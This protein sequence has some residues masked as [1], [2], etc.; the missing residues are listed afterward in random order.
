ME[1]AYQKFNK[2]VQDSYR[3]D[4]EQLEVEKRRNKDSGGRGGSSTSPNPGRD[5]S[6]NAASISR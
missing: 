4:M 2:N 5:S 3:L 6:T 1:N